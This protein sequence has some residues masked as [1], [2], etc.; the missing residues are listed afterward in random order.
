MTAPL[1]PHDLAPNNPVATPSDTP[2]GMPDFS[3]VTT[4]AIAAAAEAGLVAQRQEWEAI[5]TNPAAPDIANTLD[6]LES[7]GELLERV[8]AVFH[9]LVSS[10]ADDELR[11][12]EAELAPKLAAHADALYLDRRIFSRLLGLEEAAQA[13]LAIEPEARW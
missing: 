6:A 2:F 13:G 1:Q 10:R 11:D 7:S 8:L 3:Q 12:L 4:P 9:T 5:A